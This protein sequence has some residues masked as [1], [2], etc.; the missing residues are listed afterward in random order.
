MN[1]YDKALWNLRLRLLLCPILAVLIAILGAL[2]GMFTEL[3]DFWK[4]S[5]KRNL[6]NQRKIKQK[7]A[8]EE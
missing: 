3:E 8:E 4:N 2:L 5:V 7:K 6:A 1:K